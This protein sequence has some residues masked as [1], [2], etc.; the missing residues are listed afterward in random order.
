[1]KVAQTVE[2]TSQSCQA[3]CVNW[4]RSLGDPSGIPHGRPRG[5]ADSLCRPLL[6]PL[7][8]ASAIPTSATTYFDVNIF[9]FIG[10]SP[11]FG[12]SPVLVNQILYC[13]IRLVH[14]FFEIL[15]V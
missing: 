10:Y 6:V 1:M 7:V 4:Q 12:E 8:S 11:V 14:I 13:R 2:H 9:N 3:L 15:F 5:G